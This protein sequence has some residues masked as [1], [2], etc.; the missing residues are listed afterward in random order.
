[1]PP[2]GGEQR[3]QGGARQG[4]AGRRRLRRRGVVEPVTGAVTISHD[5]AVV[6]HEPVTDANRAQALDG[7]EMTEAVH[8]VTLHADKPI[9]TKPTVPVER[10]RAQHLA[11]ERPRR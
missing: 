2:A 7:P 11:E 8:E 1:M 5:Q 6:A 9:V 4:A 10:V 3:L